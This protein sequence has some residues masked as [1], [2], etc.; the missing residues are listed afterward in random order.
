MLAAYVENGWTHEAVLD[1]GRGGP[2]VR[3]VSEAM[4]RQDGRVTFRSKL[5]RPEDTG[6]IADPEV[7]ITGRGGRYK[8]KLLVFRTSLEDLG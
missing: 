4:S 1:R 3:G 8:K 5:I 7:K 2:C 6:V